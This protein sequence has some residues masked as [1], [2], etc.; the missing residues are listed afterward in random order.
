MKP[1]TRIRKDVEIKQG[2]TLAFP[3]TFEHAD[4]TPVDIT[5]WTI[6]IAVKIDRQEPDTEA[7]I[8]KTNTT[9]TDPVNGTTSIYLNEDDT[10]V[11]VGDY[12]FAIRIRTGTNDVREIMIGNFKVDVSPRGEI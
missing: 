8:L 2:D 10:N 12:Q 1:I 4:G 7:V 9:H 5:N 6:G 11:P 3:F